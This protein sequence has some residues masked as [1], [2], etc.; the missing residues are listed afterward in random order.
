[1]L[2]K[3][4]FLIIFILMGVCI[5]N[6]QVQQLINYQSVLTDAAGKPINGSRSIQFFIYDLATGGTVIWDE[7]QTVPITDGLF[8]VM[9]GSSKPIS[10]TVFNGSDRYLSL[11]VGTDPEMTPR[12]RLVSVGYSFR[13]YDADKVDGKDAAAFV[14]KVDG[15]GPAND[16]NIDLVAGTNVTITPD[17][18]NHKITISGGGGG[19]N[20]GNHTAIQNIKLN[21]NWLSGDGGNEG[22]FVNNVG[23]VGIGTKTQETFLEISGA[24]ANLRGQLK[25]TD[26]AGDDPFIS[27]Y[28]G[29]AYK[30]AIGY[31]N[32]VARWS[33]NDGS[34]LCI[35]GG[36]VG[37]DT[38]QPGAK[39]HVNG[40]IRARGGS[41]GA[42]GV[43]NNGYAFT[44]NNGDDDSGMFSSADGQLEFYTNNIERIRIKSNGNIGIGTLLPQEKLHVNGNLM[45]SVLKI[46][47][48]SD[49]AEPFDINNAGHI[50]AGMVMTIDPEN[51]GKLK[52]SDKAY[53][54]CVAGIISGAG[55]I[56]PG[57][58]MGQTGTVANGEYPV[59][60][61]GRVYC[62]ANATNGS[63]QPGDLLTTSETPGHAMKVSDFSRAQ[64]AILGKAMSS[65][66]EER[67]LILVLVTLQ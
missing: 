18:P 66:K 16:G 54:R 37:I 51:P 61:S 48:G 25:I 10:Y 12:K 47:G 38:Q 55:D 21:G 20:L 30:S 11:K 19:D 43:N 58:I 62:W 35:S 29:T 44:G 27:F 53:D 3:S 33:T 24:P 32:G 50:E 42:Y 13:A 22:I 40:G 65:L 2:Q 17:I 56:A 1:M 39:L 36:N 60:L 28:A 34:N 15:V 59:A 57:M 46:T 9:L 26:P 8:N 7:T 14:Q 49:I 63:I 52:I 4:I 67:G 64:G 6:A 45:C 5:I 31:S 23:N 41:P